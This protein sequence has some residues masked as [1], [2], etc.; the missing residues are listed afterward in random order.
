MDKELTIIS[1]PLL[2][3]IGLTIRTLPIGGLVGVGVRLRSGT[4]GV[5]LT[6]APMATVE[7]LVLSSMRPRVMCKR[8][9]SLTLIID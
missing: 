3:S 1:I 5:V 2:H 9:E 8:A 7:I 4:V 6:V